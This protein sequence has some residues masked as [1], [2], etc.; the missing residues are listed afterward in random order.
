[1]RAD[2][3]FDR[4]VADWLEQD[5]PDDVPASIVEA[6][7]AD[8][9]RVGQARAWRLPALWSPLGAS[10]GIPRVA[11]VLVAVALLGAVLLGAVITGARLLRPASL[12]LIAYSADG[13]AMLAEA[14]GSNA[15]A[16]PGSG[17]FSVDPRWSPDGTRLAYWTGAD[18]DQP[19]DLVVVDEGTETARVVSRA[20]RYPFEPTWSPDSRRL[21]FN[22]LDPA[23]PGVGFVYG[24]QAMYTVDAET[25]ATRR[26]I[27]GGLNPMM[28]RWSPNG[29]AIAFW[30]EGFD[31]E[32]GIYTIR[33]DGTGLRLVIVVPCPGS[34]CYQWI[35]WAPHGH[36][37]AYS[38]GQTEHDV[39][40]VNVDGTGARNL[41]AGPMN[42]VNPSWSPD[43]SKIAWYRTPRD[44]GP[45]EPAGSIVVAAA[46]G[47][48]E[49]TVTGSSVIDFAVPRWSPDGSSVIVPVYNPSARTNDR[50]GVFPIAGGPPRFLP[51]DG[52]AG[53]DA[54]VWQ[55]RQP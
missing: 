41:S 7:I 55:P 49:M 19:L 1:M 51:I 11:M 14:D 20:Q 32:D 46:D 53:G 34:D 45:N 26:L 43:G 24:P 3:R 36:A 15:R 42:D 37:I 30:G 21:T 22:A 25:G 17:A 8:A 13:R 44:F 2:T 48:A 54:A 39:W 52:G 47:S 10:R 50:Y 29:D 18:S 28:P 27:P 35:D 5:G 40:T 31:T 16:V 6:A 9:S 38:A 23:A 4:L 33:P 12:G